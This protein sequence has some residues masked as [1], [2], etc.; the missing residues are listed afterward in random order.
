MIKVLG[1]GGFGKVMLCRNKLNL[2]LYAVKVLVL[3]Q[4]KDESDLKKI[5]S[6]R[7][8]IAKSTAWAS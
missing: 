3:S 8:L 1:R 6:E 4:L 5:L 7:E 2:E